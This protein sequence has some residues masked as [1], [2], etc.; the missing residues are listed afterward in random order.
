M[1]RAN[2]SASSPLSQIKIKRLYSRLNSIMNDRQL[3]IMVAGSA[4]M[5][6]VLL[7]GLA[8]NCGFNLF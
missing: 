4:L 6:V 1:A 5:T 3:K 2:A 7:L 8:T